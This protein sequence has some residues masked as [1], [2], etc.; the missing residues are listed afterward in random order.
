VTPGFDWRFGGEE[1][2]RAIEAALATSG[3]EEGRLEV[4]S[5]RP[6]RRRLLRLQLTGGEDLVLMHFAGGGQC[7]RLRERVKNAVGRSTADRERRALEGLRAAGIA[8]PAL[9]ALAV[10]SDGGSVVATQYL[11]GTPLRDSLGGGRAERSALLDAVGALVRAL[12][13]GGRVHGN[14]HAGNIRVTRDGP[15]LLDLGA[16]R[17]SLS[18]RGRRRDLGALDHSLAGRLTTTDRVR[19]QAAA[20]GLQRPF[21]ASA[22]R[23]LRAVGRA[24]E[25]R[26]LRHAA[27]Q[28][29]GTL[30]P[31]QRF[32][33]LQFE[34]ATGLRRRELA[35]SDLLAALTA[36]RC[37]QLAGRQLS[38]GRSVLK[39][40]GRS[41][42]TAGPLPDGSWVIKEYSAAGWRRALVDLLRG[43][44]ARRAWL[45]GHGLLARGIGAAR[46]AAFLETRRWGLPVAS[47]IVLEDLRRDAP[48]DAD[49]NGVAT[50]AERVDALARLATQL[51]R[52]RID[53]GD[54][55]ASHVYLRRRGRRIEA[56]LIDLEGVK[57]RRYLRDGTRL[58]ALAQ[59]NASL[60]DDVE[61]GLRCAAF[62]RYAVAL[63]FVRG[64]DR[65]LRRIVRASLRRA[66]RWSGKGCNIA[67]ESSG[68][69]IPNVRLDDGIGGAQID[70][71]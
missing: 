26:A 63:P 36:H 3:T 7:Q 32:A 38:G 28:T 13:T 41:R 4:L 17:R 45:G 8:V 50:T 35:D 59:L 27:S 15:V 16:V 31:G 12:H 49:A 57:F 55:K 39:S 60:P 62:R 65:A 25:V 11:V 14:L 1:L 43:S 2:Q 22:R 30:A 64:R 70:R 52:R 66:H 61:A 20:M 47:A 10:L 42:V 29:R 44:P 53:H 58:R 71:D 69:C 5:H 51:H 34:G 24:S 37:A 9:R 46:P 19:L 21:D 40:D 6:G 33:S 23:A 68:A 67:G 54:L 48:A 56:R 18:E